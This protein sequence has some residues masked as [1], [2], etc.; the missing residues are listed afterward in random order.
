MESKQRQDD[1]DAWFF[2]SFKRYTNLYM[3]EFEAPV[4][5]ME[6]LDPMSLITSGIQAYSKKCEILQ[7]AVPPKLLPKDIEEGLCKD[8]DFKIISGGYSSTRIIQVQPI[9]ADRVAVAVQSDQEGL[10]LFQL[11]NDDH[12][13]ITEEKRLQFPAEQQK[14]HNS[15]VWGPGVLA[16]RGRKVILGDRNGS[17]VCQW[18]LDAQDKGICHPLPNQHH[19]LQIK[20][21][22]YWDDNVVA[23][24]TSK[25][26]ILF[27]DLLQPMDKPVTTIESPPTALASDSAVLCHSFDTHPSENIL[28]LLNSSGKFEIF[29]IKKPDSPVVSTILPGYDHLSVLQGK[30]NL[31][32]QKLQTQSPSDYYAKFIATGFKD[33]MIP[34]YECTKAGDIRPL[35]THDGHTK[36][37]TTAMW[38]TAS[39]NLLFSSS[40]DAVLHAWQY[41]EN[42]M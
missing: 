32:F 31:Q 24:C 42:E 22:Q 27:Y 7:L 17:Y 9:G 40:I 14:L 1:A 37:V 16:T 5:T 25:G 20:K 29:D 3:Y 13:V 2:E 28:G 21:I 11:G 12:G 41:I 33:E 36:I 35:F 19:V 6:L 39:D 18:S 34:V 23:F 8:R 4:D 26:S 30:F 38:H 10:G 15:S